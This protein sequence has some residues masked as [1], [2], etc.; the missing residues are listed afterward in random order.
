MPALAVVIVGERTDSLTYVAM[1]QRAFKRFGLVSERISVAG[2]ASQD[3]VCKA[4]RELNANPAYH[5]ILVQVSAFISAL[6]VSD[7][8]SSL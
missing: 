3:E 6:F 4:V 7:T 2:D 8:E 5:G 1:K